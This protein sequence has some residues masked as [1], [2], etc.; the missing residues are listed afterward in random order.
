MA[1]PQPL[2]CGRWTLDGQKLRTAVAAVNE[3]GTLT[4]SAPASQTRGG[5]TGLSSVFY[6]NVMAFGRG[7]QCHDTGYVSQAAVCVI[8]ERGGPE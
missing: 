1:P 8:A 2:D 7:N 5:A 3:D 4:S 6:R